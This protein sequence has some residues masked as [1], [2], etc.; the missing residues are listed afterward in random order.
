[1]IL[2]MFYYGIAH[3][4]TRRVYRWL[5]VLAAVVVLIFSLRHFVTM[6]LNLSGML[7]Y[8]FCELIGACLFLT[9][10][11]LPGEERS[12]FQRPFSWMA[13]G[14]ILFSCAYILIHSLWQ[15]IATW[16]KGRY[17]TLTDLANT[18]EYAGVWMTLY[19]LRK[20]RAM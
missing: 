14:V 7:F 16:P 4:T 18:F 12:I 2:L 8:L 15:Y 5:L 11:L 20:S 13:L 19:S 3:R 10:G 9:D 6:S 1:M 17:Q